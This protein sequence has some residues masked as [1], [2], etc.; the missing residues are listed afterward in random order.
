MPYQISNLIMT[1][2]DPL[3]RGNKPFLARRPITVGQRIIRPGETITIGDHIYGQVKSKLEVYVNLGLIK[4]N[5]LP[6]TVT[7]VSEPSLLEDRAE[8]VSVSDVVL[9]V[10]PPTEDVIKIS[11]ADNI[12]D[13]VESAAPE[14]VIASSEET[15]E[16]A[17]VPASTE[18][19]DVAVVDEPAA[20]E[21]KTVKRRRT[22]V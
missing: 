16:Q 14:A 3:K 22:T 8:M 17:E 1:C 20:E 9:L 13:N 6:S 12:V 18:T 5:R 2:H 11:T 21:V 19:T 15:P 4:I 7:P 10:D